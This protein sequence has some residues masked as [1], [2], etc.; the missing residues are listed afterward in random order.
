MAILGEICAGPA[1][2]GSGWRLGLA[3][4]AGLLT[5]C[6]ETGPIFPTSD[7]LD[8]WVSA[9]GAVDPRSDV[10][11]V[12]KGEVASFRLGPGGRRA[13]LRTGREW[14]LGQTYLF[15]FD[16]RIEPGPLPRQAVT[17]S[18]LERL[19][20]PGRPG[21][22]IVAVSLDSRGVSV[23]GRSCIRPA[24]LGRWH[25]VE[26]RIALADDDT[27]FLEVF[28]DRRPIWAQSHLRTVLPP[29]CRRTEGCNAAVPK[30]VRYEWQL[31][32]IAPHGAAQAIKVQMRRIFYHRLFW[33]PNRVGAL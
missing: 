17:L 10:A 28:C 21:A 6:A 15:G 22:G 30:P 8:P 26:I 7:R 2:G 16:I 24:E 4:A 25:S 23:L 5:A 9:A 32:L 20:A 12:I 29:V 13:A 19:G 1:P 33:I 27:G 18:T 11:P 14:G 31:G 3:L